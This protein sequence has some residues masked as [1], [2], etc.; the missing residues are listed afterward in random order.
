MKDAWFKEHLAGAKSALPFS[1]TYDG[2]PSARWLAE[3]PR[4]AESKKLDDARTQHTLRWT[5]P[6]T[7]LEVRCVAVDYADSPAVEWTVWFKNTGTADTPILEN[8]L[9]LDMANGVA[10]EAQP[11][12]FYSRG[13]EAR[14]D[15]FTL[16]E[17][18]LSAGQATELTSCGS[19]QALPF[20]NLDLGGR[21]VIGAV[22]W[23]ANWKCAIQRSEN[24]ASIRLCAGM[25]RT[26]LRLHPG[27]EIRTPRMLLLFWQGDRERAHNLLRRHLVAHHL[28]KLNG[29]TVEPPLCDATWGG[30]KTATHMKTLKFIEDNRLAFDCYWIDAG[31]YGPDHETEEF[32]NFHTEDWAYHIGHWRVNRVVHPDGL[33]PIADRAHELGMKLLLWFS[34][35]LAEVSSPLFKE[36]PEWILHRNAWGAQGIGMNKTTVNLCSLDIGNPE[37]RRF[38]LDYISGLI[39]EHGVDHFRDDCGVPLPPPERDAPDRQGIGEIRA[40]EGFYAF[41]DGLLRRHPG[42]LI[43]NCGGGGSRIDLE[44]ISRS[45]VLHRTDY[46]CS[47]EADPIGFQVG[48][49]GL[50][51]WVP[52]V[53]GGTPARPGDTYNFRSAWCGGLPFSLFHCCG[54]GTAATE[55]AADHPVAWHRKM[56]ADYRRVRPYL[57]GDFYPL[58]PGTPSRQEWCAWQ[59]DRPDLGEGFVMAFRRDHCK[60]AVQTYRLHGLDPAAMYEVTDFDIDGSTSLTTGKELMDK[61]L[62]VE[63]PDRPFEKM[64]PDDSLGIALPEEGVAFG[65]FTREAGVPP[66]E[67]LRRRPAELALGGVRARGRTFAFRDRVMDLGSLLKADGEVA[68]VYLPFTA[69]DNGRAVF[70]FGADWW[71]EAYLDGVVISETLSNGASGNVTNPPTVR[72]HVVMVDLQRGEHLLVLR[73]VRGSDSALLAVGGGLRD[74]KDPRFT[75]PGSAALVYRRVNKETT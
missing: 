32:Q 4:Q 46:N 24:G 60:A 16:Q 65:P 6:K 17:R 68:F 33:R 11:R 22:G 23:T 61:G 12:L 69:L 35:Y 19:R 30:M 18:A 48:T 29:R 15:D 3:W 54:F 27:E 34:P 66:A 50:S 1:F 62:T 59:M 2:Q 25:T 44:T 13:T 55:P 40:V 74:L 47:P 36:H 8:I 52:L 42:M 10:Q 57:T 53:G 5:D 45:L 41:W 39:A 71:Y 20:F 43:D 26:H 75:A 51:H 31:W 64:P 7:G 9:A 38:L 72:D 21:G 70:G 73:F 56:L 37:A 14:I 58:T 63:I 49:H 67:A 28:P